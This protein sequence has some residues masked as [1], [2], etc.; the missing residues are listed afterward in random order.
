MIT[1]SLKLT[2]FFFFFYFTFNLFLVTLKME[3]IYSDLWCT[4]EMLNSVLSDELFFFVTVKIKK[5]IYIFKVK[6]YKKNPHVQNS[7]KLANVF[8]NKKG[9]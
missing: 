6:Q 9:I 8:F 5:Y 4:E 7:G 3:R 2:I 1:L